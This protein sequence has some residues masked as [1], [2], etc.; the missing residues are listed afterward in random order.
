ME[1]VKVTRNYQ[2]TIPASLRKQIGIRIGNVLTAQVEDGRIV[3]EKRRGDVTKMKL[4]LG[5]KFDWKDVEAAAR[6]AA[7]Q[8]N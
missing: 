8:S 6:E 1:K 2:V 5:R 3:L 7:D 4:R